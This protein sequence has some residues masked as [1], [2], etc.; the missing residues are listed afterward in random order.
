MPQASPYSAA[1]TKRLQLLHELVP[2]PVAIAYLMNPKNPNADIELSAA[3]EASH[4]LGIALHVFRA[5]SE[6][7]LEAVFANMPQQQVGALI[8][9]SDTFLFGRRDQIVSLA[10]HYRIPAIYYLREFA[11]AG[12]LM[13]YGNN[14]TD[15]IAW[16][17]SMSAGFLRAKSLPT[18]RWCSRPPRVRHFMGISWV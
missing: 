7:E 18:C 5:N 6:N 1:V 10:A 15:L 3:Q 13:T 16:W 9:A 14:L 4:S 17:A 8:G 11:H 12:G 2:R